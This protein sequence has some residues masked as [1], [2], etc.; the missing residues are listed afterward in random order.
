MTPA[1]SCASGRQVGALQIL[2]WSF[3][4]VGLG[5]SGELDTG[6]TLPGGAWMWP[7]VPWSG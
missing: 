4:A 2:L 5:L 3:Q 1:W 7:L 6:V